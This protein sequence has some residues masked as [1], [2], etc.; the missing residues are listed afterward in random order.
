VLV[1]VLVGFIGILGLVRVLLIVVMCCMRVGVF[2][3]RNVRV[4]PHL[5]GRILQLQAAT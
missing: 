3:L 1:C 5:Y 4:Y 2:L